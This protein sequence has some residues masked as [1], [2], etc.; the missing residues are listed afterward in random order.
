MKGKKKMIYGGIGLF[1]VVAL[2]GGSWYMLGRSSKENTD[3]PSQTEL[4][5]KKTDKKLLHIVIFLKI[6][7]KN[8]FFNAKKHSNKNIF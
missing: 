6:F 8:I 4:S 1:C 5:V 7:Y 3:K 2:A